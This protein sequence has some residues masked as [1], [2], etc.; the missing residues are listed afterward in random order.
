MGGKS[1]G[2]VGGRRGRGLLEGQGGGKGRRGQQRRGLRGGW[3]RGGAWEGQ[4]QFQR[5]EGVVMGGSKSN[6]T[7]TF[8][9]QPLPPCLTLN[10]C[11]L[12]LGALLHL[13]MADLKIKGLPRNLPA[14]QHLPQ[15][16]RLLWKLI[17]NWVLRLSKPLIG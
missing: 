2:G 5:E 15:Y 1:A 6:A 4:G 12:G 9:L 13:K 16:L 17:Y 10:S 11:K 14:R 7:P 8:L 3:R